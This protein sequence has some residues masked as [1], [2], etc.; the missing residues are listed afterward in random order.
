MKE[1]KNWLNAL[2]NTGDSVRIAALRNEIGELERKLNNDFVEFKQFRKEMDVS[3]TEVKNGLSD[4][5]LLIDF[6][7]Y[8]GS[9]GDLV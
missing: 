2:M 3:W 4:K 9:T 8:D 1:Q 6:V 5:Q 7:S